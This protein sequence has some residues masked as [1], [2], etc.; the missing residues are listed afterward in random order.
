MKKILL[1]TIFGFLGLSLPAYAYVFT[2]PVVLAAILQQ[3]ATQ[4]SEH[5]S[6]LA[7]E[8][9]AVETLQQELTTSNGL[10]QLAQA[11]AQGA[12]NLQV[13]ANF[14]NTILS[15]NSVLQAIQ[16]DLNANQDLSGQWQTVFGSLTP[17]IQ[18]TNT[19]F[20]NI[21]ASDKLNAASYLV[22][23]SYQNLYQQNA[24]TVAQFVAS[25]NQVSEK[26]A[27]RQ[28]AQEMAELIQ[29]ENNVI[30]LLSQELK[31]QSVES[32]NDNLK[33]K[34]QIVQVQDEGQGVSDFM[35]IVD[36]N[37]FKI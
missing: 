4:T 28:I 13:M 8:I 9:Q 31:G 37:T 7:Q 26:G 14:Q 24:A 18:N 6:R 15:A 5:L 36:N 35:G 27:L 19:A 23:D 16:S 2:D 30:Y 34:E 21:D 17:F 20:T 32:A 12:D 10:L 3:T 1:L 22:G 33:R 29:M 25:A 11:N